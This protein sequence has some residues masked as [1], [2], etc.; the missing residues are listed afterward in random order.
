MT[1][2]FCDLCGLETLR[3]G[4]GGRVECAVSVEEKSFIVG[5]NVSQINLKTGGVFFVS[6][7]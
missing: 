3:T 5:V 7:N 2:T 4:Y 1:K 6:G